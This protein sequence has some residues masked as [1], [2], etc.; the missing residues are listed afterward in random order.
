MLQSEGLPDLELATGG[1]P[2]GGLPLDSQP[3]MTH[4]TPVDSTNKTF[5]AQQGASFLKRWVITTVAVLV[6]AAIV[7]GIRC[8][9]ILALILAS[10]TLGLL[11]V[12]IRPVLMALSFSL[13]IFTLGLFTFV[14]NALL[15]LFVGKL[16]SGFQVDGFAS[17]F[18]GAIVI[19]VVSTIL[20]LLTGT[21]VTV[22][23]PQ[24]GST[25]SGGKSARGR[26]D[27]D[28]PV[29]DV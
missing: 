4:V 24:M 6:A 5:M 27:G 14:I 9:S 15:L 25:G 16:T 8:S 11:N 17:A 23:R 22:V 21:S 18:W 28:G 13:L 19:S 1:L 26:D 7:P 10:L 2:P 29:I 20:N 12:F 3:R